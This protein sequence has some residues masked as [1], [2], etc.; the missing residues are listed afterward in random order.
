MASSLRGYLRRLRLFNLAAPI[1]V[2]AVLR[3]DGMDHDGAPSLSQQPPSF[4]PLP[5]VRSKL[6]RLLELLEPD[7]QSIPI[8]TILTPSRPVDQ[9]SSDP[10]Q[11]KFEE[12]ALV[13]FEQP[14][15]DVNSVNR[16]GP[17]RCASH[18]A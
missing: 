11:P 2:E 4:L 8:R 6:C 1:V 15:G 13:D 10:L 9:C 3:L 14:I 7:R 17:I 16:V 12:R 5:L 18:A